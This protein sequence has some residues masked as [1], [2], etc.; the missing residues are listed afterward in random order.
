MFA[1]KASKNT[2]SVV[3]SVRTG[4]NW[5]CL[6]VERDVVKQMRIWQNKNIESLGVS[7][8]CETWPLPTNPAGPRIHTH[9]LVI[10]PSS[11]ITLFLAP[12]VEYCGVFI[13]FIAWIYFQVPFC[14]AF[15][16]P[17]CLT[18]SSEVHLSLPLPVLQSCSSAPA[19][20]TIAPVWPPNV[21]VSASSWMPWQQPLCCIFSLYVFWVSFPIFSLDLAWFHL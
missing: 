12:S 3:N 4:R 15:F 8:C 6:R 10:C 11:P 16:L 7:V 13:L 20:S 9:G 14:C 18:A 5:M 21:T 19:V 17:H 1:S 2:C